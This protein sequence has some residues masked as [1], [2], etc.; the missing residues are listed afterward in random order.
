M[1][2]TRP[3]AALTVV[4]LVAAACGGDDESTDSTA[5]TTTSSST[6]T[7]VKPTTT[8]GS[9]TTVPEETIR[10]PLTGEPLDSE[11][12]I[13]QRAA[14]V[15]KIDNN[16]AAI[17]NH[18]GIAA[19]DIVYEEVVEG[20]TTRLAAVFHS[21]SAETIGPIRSGR[22]Q[23]INLFTSYN[24]PLFVWSGGN[25]NVT[26][27]IDASPLI[28]MGPNHASGYYRGPGRAPHN[29]YN[30]TDGIWFQTPEGQPGPPP[31]QFAYLDEGED[32]D[33]TPSAGLEVSV[34]SDTVNWDWN[35][36]SGSFDRT[37]RGRPHEDTLSGRV[38]ATNVIV[39]G[40][41][42]RPS[43]ADSRSPEAQTIGSGIVWIWSDGK[44]VQGTWEREDSAVPIE[45]L[46]EDGDP[47]ALQPGNTWVELADNADIVAGRV[48]SY[49][50]SAA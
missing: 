42:Y 10:Q 29:L 45:Y 18:S 16:A 38:T 23:D 44:V 13:L 31:E 17:P 21:Q 7:T 22:T 5:L 39:M 27:M 11:D 47:I 8:T 30:S 41:D 4:A 49:P 1:K 50:P 25:A 35:E 14:L 9:T 15:V 24:S 34:G 12:D 3:F 37:F 28:N 6:T 40:V 20:R 2:L 33:G 36:E 46:D 26:R 48:T 43:V 32:F 19:A